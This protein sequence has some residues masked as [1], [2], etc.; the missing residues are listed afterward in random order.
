MKILR[1][2]LAVVVGFIAGSF[3]NMML[4]TVGPKLIP[5]PPEVD[6]TDPAKLAATIH[7]LEPRHYVFPFLAHALGTLV[8]SLVAYLVAASHQA[9]LARVIGAL[10]LAGG[11]VASRMI[12]A[13]VGF[14]VLDLAL[15]YLPMT[16]VA[17]W[18]ARRWRKESV[19]AT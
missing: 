18:L 5:V 2:I 14:V 9:L 6:V 19:A 11:I 1:N 16:W 4:V 8:G 15:A 17:V 3:V 13:P 7:L 10:F 12:P